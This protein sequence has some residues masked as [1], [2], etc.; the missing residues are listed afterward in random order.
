MKRILTYTFLFNATFAVTTFV[1][2]CVGIASGLSA[3]RII[4]LATVNEVMVVLVALYIAY[5]IVYFIFMAII[6]SNRK[7]DIISFDKPKKN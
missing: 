7:K 6:R 4:S 3:L 2:L 1:L 5:V